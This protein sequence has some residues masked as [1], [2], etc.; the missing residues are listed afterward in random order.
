MARETNPDMIECLVPEEGDDAKSLDDQAPFEDFSDVSVVWR[1]TSYTESRMEKT[2]KS[3]RTVEENG[4]FRSSASL[5]WSIGS[6]KV[7]SKQSTVLTR[8]NGWE[9]WMRSSCLCWTRAWGPLPPGR[10][11]IGSTWVFQHKKN[12]SDEVVRC[13]AR[14]VAQG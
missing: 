13:K 8:Q 1:R 6:R 7:T 12:S 10:Q 11:P 9:L 5:K 3:W 4:R 2:I 14:H